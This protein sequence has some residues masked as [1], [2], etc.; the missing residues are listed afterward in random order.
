[1]EASPQQGE[2]W[3]EMESRLQA[4]EGIYLLE[5]QAL[6]QEAKQK[7]HNNYNTK[8]AQQALQAQQANWPLHTLQPQQY[9]TNFT[10]FEVWHIPN[11]GPNQ[12]Q[13][14]FPHLP[15]GH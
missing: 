3:A 4:L 11:P 13:P 6:A 12:D 10:V 7:K 8:W 15:Q 2:R 5:E 1:M 9:P 14:S